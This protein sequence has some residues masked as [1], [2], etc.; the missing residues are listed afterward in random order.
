VGARFIGFAGFFVQ[1]VW[2]NRR[3]DCV[4]VICMLF[5]KYFVPPEREESPGTKVDTGRVAESIVG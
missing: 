3:T 4:E 5:C 2:Y 1:N